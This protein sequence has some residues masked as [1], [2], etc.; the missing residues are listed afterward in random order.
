MIIWNFTSA[1]SFV[2]CLLWNFCEFFNLSLGKYAPK[3]FGYSIGSK[4]LKKE[5][6]T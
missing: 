5:H 3:I 6:R 1:R 4:P 2:A